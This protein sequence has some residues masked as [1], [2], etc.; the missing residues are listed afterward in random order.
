[1]QIGVEK[2]NAFVRL[3]DAFM[4]CMTVAEYRK[5]QVIEVEETCLLF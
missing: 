1:M 2:A 5:Q 3:K 4:H